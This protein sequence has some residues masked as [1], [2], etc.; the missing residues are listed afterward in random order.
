MSFTIKVE[1]VQ[2]LKTNMQRY[3]KDVSSIKEQTS[4]L[5]AGGVVIQRASKKRWCLK[6]KEDHYYYRANQKTKILSGNLR[7]SMYVFKLRGGGIQVGP[8]VL[9]SLSGKKQIGENR[10][11]SSGYYAHMIYGGAS[12]FRQ[13]ITEPAMNNNLQKINNAMFNALTKINERLVKKYGF[14]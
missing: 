10:R 9:R 4:I 11:N 13:K 2:Q 6:S 3:L 12:E 7:N 14:L 1:N 5:R 8:R